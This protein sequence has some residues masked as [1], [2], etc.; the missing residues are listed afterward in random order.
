MQQN[1]LALAIYTLYSHSV[2]LSSSSQLFMVQ[3]KVW[4]SF[5]HISGD[6]SWKHNTKSPSANTVIHCYIWGEYFPV[7]SPD[8]TKMRKKRFFFALLENLT[9]AYLKQ[10]FFCFIREI[11]HGVIKI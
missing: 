5:T 1:Q 7:I 4:Q 9:V 3:L 11:N 8:N 6:I 2:E 10:R